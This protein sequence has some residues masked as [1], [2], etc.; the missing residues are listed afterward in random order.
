M[1][2]SDKANLARIRDNQ[3]RSR[4]RRKEYLQELEGRLRQCE[5][6]GVEASSEI[7][8]A[9][10][11]VIEENRKVT[12]QN[13]RLRLL[14]AQHGVNL[15]DAS[16]D[17]VSQQWSANNTP[18]SDDAQ[19]LEMLLN[20][21]RWKCTE[22]QGSPPET[23][24]ASTM[25]GEQNIDMVASPAATQATWMPSPE[26]MEDQGAEQLENSGLGLNTLQTG[27]AASPDDMQYQGLQK[28]SGESDPC[29]PV[30]SY[31]YTNQCCGGNSCTS[32]PREQQEPLQQLQPGGLLGP[33]NMLGPMATHEEQRKAFDFQVQ[34]QI[35]PNQYRYLQQLHALYDPSK[36]LYNPSMTPYQQTQPRQIQLPVRPGPSFQA[37]PYVIGPPRSTPS[38]QTIGTNSCIYATDMITAMATD[39]LPSDVRT[40]LGCSPQC[41]TDCEMASQAPENFEPDDMTGVI[42]P[43]FATTPNNRIFDLNARL[44]AIQLHGSVAVLGPRPAFYDSSNYP[45]Q[46]PVLPDEDDHHQYEV[47]PWGRPRETLVRDDDPFADRNVDQGEADDRRGTDVGELPQF[48]NIGEY[49]R[50]RNSAGDPVFK[51]IAPRHAG[52]KYDIT[53]FIDEELKKDPYALDEKYDDW[54]REV[55]FQFGER[56]P[57]PPPSLGPA[58]SPGE[59]SYDFSSLSILFKNRNIRPLLVPHPD[60]RSPLAPQ[61]G[62]DK[63]MDADYDRINSLPL[64]LSTSWWVA[65]ILWFMGE[66]DNSL[67]KTIGMVGEGSCPPEVFP[68]TIDPDNLEKLDDYQF[69]SAP[70]IL[71]EPLSVVDGGL[72]PVENSLW[73]PK[74]KGVNGSVVRFIR[75]P[76]TDVSTLDTRYFP[77]P[78]LQSTVLPER[79][80]IGRPELKLWDGIPGHTF[81]LPPY[82]YPDELK[83]SHLDGFDRPFGVDIRR[84]PV[85]PPPGTTEPPSPHTFRPTRRLNTVYRDRTK[86]PQN[87]K[88]TYVPPVDTPTGTSKH[89][90]GPSQLGGDSDDDDPPPSFL[91]DEFEYDTKGD[92]WGAVGGFEGRDYDSE[93]QKDHDRWYRYFLINN[94]PW[95]RTIVVNG[96]QVKPGAIAGPLPSFAIL[97]LDGQA[98]FW[99][100]VGGRDFD[101]NTTTPPEKRMA[102][103]DAFGDEHRAKAARIFLSRSPGQATGRPLTPPGRTTRPGGVFLSPMTAEI[104]EFAPHFE[105][106]QTQNQPPVRQVPL[107]GNAPEFVPGAFGGL[108]RLGLRGGA[109]TEADLDPVVTQQQSTG[110]PQNN[111]TGTSQNIGTGTSQNTGTRTQ[112]DFSSPYHFSM[113]TPPD[114]TAGIPQYMSAETPP[115]MSTGALESRLERL[116]ICVDP[117]WDRKRLLDENLKV[118]KVQHYQSAHEVER[119]NTQ[120]GVAQAETAARARAERMIA[121]VSQNS[122]LEQRHMCE[123]LGIII[124][125]EWSPARIREEIAR[126]YETAYQELM[127]N[128]NAATE[129]EEAMGLPVNNSDPEEVP[130]GVKVLFWLASRYMY[131][132]RS[133]AGLKALCE[134]YCIVIHHTWDSERVIMEIIRAVERQRQIGMA[135]AA[136][137]QASI[138]ASIAAIAA[139]HAETSIIRATMAEMANAAKAKAGPTVIDLTDT[140]T[141][142]DLT[143][144]PT[145]VDLTHSPTPIDLTYSP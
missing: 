64:E 113:V 141:V 95:E 31:S 52:G 60:I 19:A 94:D 65:N 43:R 114:M 5:L 3:R 78:A 54:R 89:N 103:D 129:Y 90:H 80:D 138:A 69:E 91:Q 51:H 40:D 25:P 117:S 9:A 108:E 20:I 12:E 23:R 116:G 35:D 74:L 145:R 14:L 128:N 10:R 101:P 27:W 59:A 32:N 8:G 122:E 134:K 111:G 53:T 4:A 88:R 123:G 67:L 16:D 18:K 131:R 137:N 39:A 56:P 100:G 61:R 76:F 92:I 83:D 30:S 79:Y 11:K 77:V 42:D 70:L 109:G 28:L 93:R 15:D 44:A 58:P 136:V 17:D 63:E 29:T 119:A 106:E 124:S 133:A 120:T 112:Y 104:R 118:K 115:F 73:I 22:T 45:Q 96:V 66:N 34:A 102:E 127:S 33:I 110:T 21:R 132:Q 26:S 82:F 126:L 135:R 24:P 143:E 81:R 140:S 57:P 107:R 98:A 41:G 144:N 38:A 125:P 62:T 48:G 121:A 87:R 85:N 37:P 50:K 97:E 46:A 7:Q 68:F 139:M 36:A 142:I 86:V 75:P 49:F 71:Y 13:Q 99:F 47:D 55:E 2:D 1:P 105:F 84:I 6:T 72:D 130:D